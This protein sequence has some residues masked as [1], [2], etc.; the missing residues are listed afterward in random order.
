MERSLRALP[1][2]IVATVT[3]FLVVLVV[4]AGF[5]PDGPWDPLEGAGLAAI[6]VGVLPR[7]LEDHLTTV[8]DGISIA[9]AGLVCFG[10]GG[11]AARRDGGS[12]PLD[13]RLAVPACLVVAAGIVAWPWL[14]GGDGS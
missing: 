14:A 1:R 13:L 11:L 2:T 5:L 6:V 3:L 7:L 9:L 10:I 4:R 12:I 8:Q